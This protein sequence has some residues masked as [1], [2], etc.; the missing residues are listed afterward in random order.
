MKYYE[1][2]LDGEIIKLRLTTRDCKVIEKKNNMSILDYIENV[3]I[4]TISNILMY[5][6]RSDVPNFSEK[7]ADDLLDK[8]VDNGYTLEDIMYKVIY[9]GLVVSGFLSHQA[10]QEIISTNQEVKKKAIAKMTEDIQK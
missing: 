4:T 1:L 8:L 2:E 7:D 9:E 6:R 10:L 3:S 5:M